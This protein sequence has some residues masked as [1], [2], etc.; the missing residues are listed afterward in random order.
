MV[1]VERKKKQTFCK[2]ICRGVD[3]HQLLDVS[4]RQLM[5]L[6]SAHQRRRLNPGLHQKITPAQT[7]EKPEAVKTHLRD[8]IILPKMVGSVVGVY[9]GKTFIQMEMIGHYLVSHTVAELG[10]GPTS[11]AGFQPNTIASI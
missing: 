8:M 9:N 4:S 5:L 7:M 2:F 3:F 1:E 6:E 11:A 10:L